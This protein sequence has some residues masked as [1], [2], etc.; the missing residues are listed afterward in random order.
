MTTMIYPL[1]VLLIP[2]IS[3]R[4]SARNVASVAIMVAVAKRKPT[5]ALSTAA[6]QFGH[7]HDMWTHF[8]TILDAGYP[9]DP[10]DSETVYTDQGRKA[11]ETTLTANDS[12]PHGEDVKCTKYCAQQLHP[13]SAAFFPALEPDDTVTQGFKH[14]ELTH[15]ICPQWPHPHDWLLLLFNKELFNMDDL[16]AIFLRNEMLV[17][18]CVSDLTVF[19]S[20]CGN[21]AV[22]QG[23]R[24]IFQGPRAVNGQPS[25]KSKKC[26]V[27][28]MNNM[29]QVTIGGIA[30]ISTL[31]YFV[32]GSQE[33]FGAGNGDHDIDF[34]EFYRGLVVLVEN[35][36]PP[37]DREDLLAWWNKQVFPNYVTPDE[38]DSALPT[39]CGL[40]KAQIRAWATLQE[41][42][43]EGPN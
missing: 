19:L 41:S 37:E 39:I 22:A 33:T 29:K 16:F 14:A 35:E 7:V 18:I 8:T 27:S 17:H 25:G 38:E 1:E 15:L 34:F 6:C 23:W 3:L 32:L 13:K 36:T 10:D 9:Y 31:V 26:G 40:M 20:W 42:T 5:D 4:L 12:T 24:M 30:Y 28:Q 11:L 2:T 43:N 21:P